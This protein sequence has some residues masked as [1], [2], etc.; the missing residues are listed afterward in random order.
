MSVDKLSVLKITMAK[1][2]S[3]GACVW[4]MRFPLKCIKFNRFFP[5]PSGNFLYAVV[6]TTQEVRKDKVCA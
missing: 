3:T 6:A 4:S 2:P 5:C 1:S